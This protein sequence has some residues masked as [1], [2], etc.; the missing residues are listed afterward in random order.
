MKRLVNILNIVA[1]ALAL[2]LAGMTYVVYDS[3]KK[4]KVTRLRTYR[5][6]NRI[7]FTT[8]LPDNPAKDFNEWI[9]HIHSQIKHNS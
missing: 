3:V 6:G 8:T 1:F 9:S 4:K 5:I 7:G 2:P